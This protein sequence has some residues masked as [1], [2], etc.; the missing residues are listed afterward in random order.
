MV[1]YYFMRNDRHLAVKLRRKGLSYNKISQELDIPKSTISY[2]FKNEAWSQEIKTDLEKRALRVA[3]KRLRLINK[4]RREKW[5][6][7]HNE[8]RKKAKK[9]FPF[10]KNDP[11]F[12]A[13]LVIYW[14]EGDSKVSNSLVRVSNTDPRMMHIFTD[15][16]L[17][18]GNI[19]HKELRA[20]LILYP[21]LNEKKC[22]D[23]W[24][25]GTGIPVSQF[26]KTQV[27]KGRHPTKRLSYGICIV[28]KCN[29]ELK[30]KILQWIDLLSE[31]ILMRV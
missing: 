5:E 11:L 15:F 26:I 14:G 25:E 2:W 23:Y 4:A 18:I 10:L 30:E 1:Q 8:C 17:K 7:W 12:I 6:R 29:R 9:E 19:P 27:I 22:L 28:Y 20:S 24:A 3:K 16:L 21:D 31:E 13:G